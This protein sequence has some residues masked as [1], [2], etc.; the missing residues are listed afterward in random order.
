MLLSYAC[1]LLDRA[2]GTQT[3][4][5]GWAYYFGAVVEEVETA[6]RTNVCLACGARN[7]FTPDGRNGAP[8]SA[9]TDGTRRS[10]SR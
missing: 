1:R 6:P 8:G 2:F 4:V 5:Y 9:R 10:V 3:S 7:L